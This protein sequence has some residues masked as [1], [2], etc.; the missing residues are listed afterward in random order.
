MSLGAAQGGTAGGKARAKHGKK[1]SRIMENMGKYMK[2][3]YKW[4]FLLRKFSLYIYVL[5]I[6]KWR[7]Y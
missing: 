5:I 2:I 3:H 6:C 1:V 7:F 4:M